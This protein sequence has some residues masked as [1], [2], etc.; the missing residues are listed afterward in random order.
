MDSEKQ[1]SFKTISKAGEGLFKE[2]GSKFLGF[3]VPV[4]NHDDV[5]HY[6]EDLR[7][8]HNNARHF[9][10][11][12]RINPRQIYE[13]ANDDGEPKH[14]A[15]TP[16]LGQLIAHELVNTLVVVVRYFG[17]TKLGIPGLI[18]AYKTAAT[19]AISD[20]TIV[21]EEFKAKAELAF[22]Y[23]ELNDVMIVVKRYEAKILK[24]SM[25]E[26]VNFILQLREDQLKLIEGDFNSF[27]TVK[28]RAL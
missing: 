27:K 4:S 22:D 28:F 3:A 11:A 19:L 9:C 24:Q 15:G 23:S 21:T 8:A 5:K 10:Y 7:K 13:R 2:R 6:L 14:S 17:G 20:A 25:L 12:Y 26:S 1:V 18:N 16:I